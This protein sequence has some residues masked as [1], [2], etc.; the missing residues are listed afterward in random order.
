MENT[1]VKGKPRIGN[2]SITGNSDMVG[3]QYNK[4]RIIGE[5]TIAGDVECNRMKCVGTFDLEGDLKAAD[6][7]VV[8]TVTVL[9]DIE[10]DTMKITGTISAGGNVVLKKLSCSGSIESKG[11]LLSEEIELNGHVITQGDCE[12]EVLKGRGIFTIGGLLNVGELDIKLYHDCQAKEIGAER[13]NIRRASLL[14]HLNFFFKPSAG[15][16]LS[17]AIIEGDEIYL[18]HTK[19][20]IVRGKRVTIGPGCE[21]ELVEYKE[22]YSEA[23]GTAVK[24]KRKV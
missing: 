13:I 10:A 12:A 22:H 3:G 16:I 4:I 5:G 9:G 14:N 19:A 7:A 21:I 6:V 1:G 8:G 18:E 2:L 11:N 24:E 17:A 23:K 20:R 15:A